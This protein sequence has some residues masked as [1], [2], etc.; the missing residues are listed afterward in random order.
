[1]LRTSE[2]TMSS[3]DLDESDIHSVLEV[4]RGGRLALGP[5]A[6]AFEECG[7]IFLV[8]LVVLCKEDTK[9]RAHRR[10]CLLP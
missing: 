10:N 4:L 9:A 2:I 7:G 6:G 5:M 8:Y 3:A 1:M